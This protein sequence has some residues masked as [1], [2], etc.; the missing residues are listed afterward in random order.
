MK[1]RKALF[2]LHFGQTEVRLNFFILIFSPFFLFC[3]HPQPKANL[4]PPSL[5]G[6]VEAALNLA[7]NQLN[8]ACYFSFREAV[9]ILEP[10]VSLT[11]PYPGLKAKVLSLYAQSVLLLGL[12]EKELG[13]ATSLLSRVESM[14]LQN[15]DLAELADYYE[16]ARAVPVASKG[17]M[18]F[19]DQQF[20]RR[21]KSRDWE[22]EKIDYERRLEERENRQKKLAQKAQQDELAAYFWLTGAFN[23]YAF[24][25]REINPPDLLSL[26]PQS[27]LV[28]FKIAAGSTPAPRRDILTELLE[29]EP[30]FYEAHYFL[31][32]E[33]FR[34]GRLLTA[35]KHYLEAH[36][37]I[38]ES[39][40]ITISLASVYFHL[41]ELERSL[42][43]YE[44][45]LAILPGYR[46]AMLGRAICLSYLGRHEEAI[47]A[48]QEM[49]DLGYWLMGEAH[50]WMAWNLYQLN[51]FQDA[52][53]H[54]EEAKGRLPTSSEVF[55]LTGL[56]AL[57]LNNL[58]QAEQNFLKALEFNGAN[59]EALSGLGRVEARRENWAS[60]AAYYEASARVYENQEQEIL[61]RIEEIKAAD[62]S[63][64]RKQAWLRRKTAQQE[65]VALNKA[66]ACYNAAT[67]YFNAGLM[68]KAL[69]LIEKAA[70]HPAFKQKALDLRAKIKGL[71]YSE[72]NIPCL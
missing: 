59:V 44:A 48:L 6:E 62:M 1:R 14:I 65:N 67:C 4:V 51:Q 22:K 24:R 56:V 30:A 31:G 71:D 69:P 32:E 36:K 13:I 37:F 12:R 64:E 11:A 38:P 47:K 50:F 20:E 23:F 42:E 15:K 29:E 55:S 5:P 46:E 26:F 72:K 28:R 45:S 54:S 8:R 68:D 70:L 18:A 3:C 49:I 25:E 61:G 35:E 53:H 27:R 19:D 40:I 2:L 39:P 58:D 57:E 41:E 7:Q 16:I 60:A 33:A 17:I 66:T 52:W 9:K 10:L 21:P 34:R 63:P 43:M